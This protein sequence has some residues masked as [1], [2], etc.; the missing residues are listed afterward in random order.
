MKPPRAEGVLDIT[1][2]DTRPGS[3]NGDYVNCPRTSD[4]RHKTVRTTKCTSGAGRRTLQERSAALHV[5]TFGANFAGI[6]INY[7]RIHKNQWSAVSEGN[8]PAYQDLVAEM[9]IQQL[10]PLAPC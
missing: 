3:H 5:L 1:T 6:P 4:Q 8:Q 10:F 2:N 9:N 7:L